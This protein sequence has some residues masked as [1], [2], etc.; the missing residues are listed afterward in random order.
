MEQLLFAGPLS[1]QYFPPGLSSELSLLCKCAQSALE[2]KTCYSLPSKQSWDTRG[3]FLTGLTCFFTWSSRLL[4]TNGII[5]VKMF[6]NIPLLWNVLSCFILVLYSRK[7]PVVYTGCLHKTALPSGYFLLGDTM[8]ILRAD[9]SQVLCKARAISWHSTTTYNNVN[10][11]ILAHIIPNEPDIILS[12]IS[13]HLHV[14]SSSFVV[15]LT[16]AAQRRELPHRKLRS[17]PGIEME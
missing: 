1:W 2:V 14:V 8:S 17:H 7:P 12:L 4:S 11:S 9:E 16:M 6:W 5:S 13:S 10:W 3:H 15:V